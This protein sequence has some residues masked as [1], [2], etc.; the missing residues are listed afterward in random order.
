MAKKSK[1]KWQY[2]ERLVAAV[3][4]AADAGADV[5]WNDTINGR[6]FDVTIRFR[7]GMYDHLTV[8]ECKDF[9][10][11]VPVEKVEA[12]VTKSKDANAN[13]AVLAS[14]SGFQ[15]GALESAQRHGIILLHVTSAD[16]VDPSIFGAKFGETVEILVVEEIA[17]EF[18]DGEKT[19]L[20]SRANVLTYYSN[21][22]TLECG[23][24]KATLDSLIGGWLKP[25]DM[26]NIPDGEHTIPMPEGTII[27]GP[28]DGAVPLKPLAAIRI[29]TVRTKARTLDGPNKVDPSF[30][31]PDVRVQNISTG[32]EKTFKYKD[33]A[34]GIDNT[35][36]PGKFYEAPGLGFFYYCEGVENGVAALCLVESFQHGQLVQGR[37]K[38]KAQ[39]GDRYIPVSDKVTI[40]RLQRRLNT[41]KQNGSWVR[42]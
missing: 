6:Q 9:G 38:M 27:T 2:F 31:T 36:L 7:K 34:L 22:T 35:F 42:T 28:H 25:K 5:K 19:Q 41:L 15:S 18:A 4:K 8:V 30:M 3:H 40:A 10:K 16:E 13:L 33:L 1:S 26:L 12:F 17:L 29:R 23:G 21:H 20:P 14:T 39:Y 37:I 24:D 32:E 11:S